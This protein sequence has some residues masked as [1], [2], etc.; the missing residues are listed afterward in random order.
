MDIASIDIL[1]MDIKYVAL[2]IFAYLS[3]SIST[4]I[5]ICQLMNLSDPRVV[6]SHNPGATNVMRIGG[7]KAAG[8]TLLGDI[9]KT[10]LPIIL[11][12]IL[13]FT[14]IQASW[15]GVCALLG[16]CFSVFFK[17]RGGKGVASMI[18][19]LAL[20]APKLTPLAIMSWLIIAWMLRK[21]SI[22]SL[23]TAII[24]PIFAYQFESTLFLS[25]SFL[26][27]VVVL[28]HKTN[29]ANIIQGKEPIISQKIGQ[30]T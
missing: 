9:F 8:A 1:S 19:V 13:N 3:G 25:L 27:A 16:H 7:L 20:I 4:A 29:I 6:G 28:R 24:I 10:A 15:V 17:F 5:L 23:L 14:K 11:A 12:L 2:L 21:S 22:A 18:A 30:T 26:S